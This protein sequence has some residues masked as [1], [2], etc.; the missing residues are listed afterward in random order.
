MRTLPLTLVAASLLAAACGMDETTARK[1]ATARKLPPTETQLIAQT[2]A[3]QDTSAQLLISSGVNPNARQ[4][5]GVT[6]LMLASF[7]GQHDT[8]KALIEKGADVNAVANGY[9]AL[10]FAV[11]KGDLVMLKMLMAAGADPGAVP[12]GGRSAVQR[13]AGRSDEAALLAIL[14]SK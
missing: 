9:N 3:G 13:A 2:K 14:Q 5:N 10:G 1:E 6:V 7:Q 8:A 4:G 11:E 12:T